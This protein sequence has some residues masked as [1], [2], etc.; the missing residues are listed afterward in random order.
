MPRKARINS[1]GVLQHVM[2]RG[3]EGRDL[4]DDDDHIT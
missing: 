4:F 1:P 3:L 2:A